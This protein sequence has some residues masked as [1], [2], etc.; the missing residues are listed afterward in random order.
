M[1]VER[2]KYQNE[3]LDSRHNYLTKVIIIVS[4]MNSMRYKS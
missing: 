4:S 2:N 1:T 3:L